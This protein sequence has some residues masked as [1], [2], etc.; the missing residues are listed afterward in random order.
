MKDRDLQTRLDVTYPY[1]KIEEET[2][3]LIESFMEPPTY[4]VR[5]LYTKG[6]R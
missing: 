2:G 1:D 3:K 6:K 4:D 5:F